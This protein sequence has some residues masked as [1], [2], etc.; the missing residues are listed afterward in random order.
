MQ[1]AF[2]QRCERIDFEEDVLGP[3]IEAMKSG[4]KGVM[5]MPPGA[6]FEMEIIDEAPAPIHSTG[7]D[8]QPQPDPAA[9]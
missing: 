9:E 4:N 1:F 5:G 7:S 3:E 6:L 2:K 8:A